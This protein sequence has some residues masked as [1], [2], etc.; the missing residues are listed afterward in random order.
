MREIL[1]IPDLRLY[2]K[3]R[4][5]IS[6]EDIPK[7][8]VED[9]QYY[10]KKSCIPG[11]AA[12]QLGESIRLIS[13]RSNEDIVFLVNP[14][15]VKRSEQTFPSEEGCLSINR[16]KSSFVLRRNKIVKVKAK[17][18]NMNEVTYKSRDLLGIALQ[19]EIDHLDGILIN[20][21]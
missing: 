11:I 5:I 20:K 13:V 9:M 19:H 6:K 4:I 1:Q 2:R 15:I 8:L 12:P 21:G 18:L 3:S 14:E 10:M 7:S 16:G 17:D